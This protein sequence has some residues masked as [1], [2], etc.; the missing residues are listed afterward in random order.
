MRLPRLGSDGS[1]LTV[2]CSLMIDSPLSSFARVARHTL[3]V[4]EA[5]FQVARQAAGHGMQVRR[6]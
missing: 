3:L 6:Q 1:F 4:E 5:Q 2:Y